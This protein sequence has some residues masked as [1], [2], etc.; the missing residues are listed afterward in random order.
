MSNT[1]E[2]Q[3][4]EVPEAEPQTNLEDIDDDCLYELFPS[5]IYPRK[6]TLKDRINR[7]SWKGI[8]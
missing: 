1:I 6:P 5:R 2:T 3:A 7:A 8:P 4:M